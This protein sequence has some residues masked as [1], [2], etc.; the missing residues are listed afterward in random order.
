LPYLPSSVRIKAAII[1]N[2][3]D[4]IESDSSKK[5]VNEEARQPCLLNNEERRFFGGEI[6]LVK[7]DGKIARRD[8]CLKGI[9]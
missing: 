2:L 6:G 7:I 3:R 1:H 5:K 4:R 8:W 9:W